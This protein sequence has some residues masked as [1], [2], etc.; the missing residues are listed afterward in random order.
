[1]RWLLLCNAASEYS[2]VLWRSE[3]VVCGFALD[4]VN[5]LSKEFEDACFVGWRERSF[6]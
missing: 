5:G 6:L 1:M 4:Y 3:L 2:E